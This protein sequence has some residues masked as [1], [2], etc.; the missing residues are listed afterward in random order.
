M[1]DRGA[2]EQ[3]SCH[4][5]EEPQTTDENL[6][7]GSYDQPSESVKYREQPVLEV[8]VICIGTAE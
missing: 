5:Q 6:A 4:Q 1:A 8:V 2:P 7:C 3:C